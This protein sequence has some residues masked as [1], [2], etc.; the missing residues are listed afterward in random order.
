VG[1]LDRAT[2]SNV[3]E[4]HKALYTDALGPRL[5][6]IEE[7]FQTWLVDAEPSWDGLFVE[8]NTNEVLKADP[9]QRFQTHLVAQQ[10]G[11]TTI[12]ERRRAENLPAIDDPLADA[13][14]VP[15]NML[16]VGK[17]VDTDAFT[18][19]DADA[20]DSQGVGATD[21][22]TG[23]SREQ[24]LQDAMEAPHDV[25]LTLTGEGSDA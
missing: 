18:G 22:L 19:G 11:V 9:A 5:T 16:P 2:F 8:F 15:L 14:M 3:T 24:L 7:A 4:L 10:A 17:D 1:I 21:N 20:G 25:G 6:L 23:A 13:V 12:N